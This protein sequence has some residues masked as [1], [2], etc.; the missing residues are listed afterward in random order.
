MVI[1]VLFSGLSRHDGVEVRQ[2]TEV[3]SVLYTICIDIV[4]RFVSIFAIPHIASFNRHINI[5]HDNI[6]NDFFTC[7]VGHNYPQRKPEICNGNVY[8]NNTKTEVF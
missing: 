2:G 5:V 3:Y 7:C 8:G 4:Q 6:S 1:T